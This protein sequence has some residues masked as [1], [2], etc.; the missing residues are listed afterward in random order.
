MT[1]RFIR[2]GS[3]TYCQVR[4]LQ[5]GDVIRLI[6]PKEYTVVRL[7]IYPEGDVGLIT[8]DGLCRWTFKAWQEVTVV[9]TQEGA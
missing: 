4:D 3:G 1:D 8:T 2:T 5:A 9:R 7:M 6:G